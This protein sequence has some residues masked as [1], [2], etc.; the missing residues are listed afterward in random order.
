VGRLPV[1]PAGEYFKMMNCCLVYVLI[2]VLTKKENLITV[3]YILIESMEH[4][5]VTILFK[6]TGVF[7]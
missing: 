6:K 2:I 7:Q 1:A 3:M 5:S 4:L